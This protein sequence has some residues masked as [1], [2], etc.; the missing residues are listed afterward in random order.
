MAERFPVDIDGERT[1]AVAYTATDPLGLTLLLGHGVS[2][3]QHGPFIVD[4]A[5]ELARRG[6]LVVTYD[7]PLAEHGRATRNATELEACCR[8]AIVAAR[9]C[10]PK[11]R[12]FVGGKSLSGRIASR[13][14]AEGGSEMD[15]VTG[16]LILGYPLHAVGKPA[17][18]G[19]Q[20]LSRVE[21]PVFIA[22]GERDALGAPEEVRSVVAG[23]PKGSELYVVEGG[24]HSFVVSRREPRAQE[25]VHA[26][27]QEEIVRWMV[28]VAQSSVPLGAHARPRPVAARKREQLRL[29]H[30]R[31]S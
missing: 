16:L 9:Q 30:R 15:D 13:V 29:L 25:K 31:P 1:T 20:H 2:G 5:T 6:V 19:A 14:A 11:N 23:L 22:Q 28:Q 4:Y 27:V 3:D 26:R 24:D 8:A 10:H 18:R 21:V 17:L 7:F 12:L